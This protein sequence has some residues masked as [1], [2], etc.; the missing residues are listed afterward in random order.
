[1]HSPQ[2]R[3]AAAHASRQRRL[4]SS[5]I[6]SEATVAAVRRLDVLDG[7]V[8]LVELDLRV[9]LLHDGVMTTRSITTTEPISLVLAARA[10]PGARL[11]VVVSRAGDDELAIEW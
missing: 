6:R 2:V 9:C 1:M 10:Q 3:A 7:G 8:S 11:D 4:R 5:G